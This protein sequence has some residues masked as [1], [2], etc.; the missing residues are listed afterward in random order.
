MFVSTFDDSPDTV[1]GAIVFLALVMISSHSCAVRKSF[2][3]STRGVSL[4][5]AL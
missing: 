4:T 3:T 1:D 5:T 2:A